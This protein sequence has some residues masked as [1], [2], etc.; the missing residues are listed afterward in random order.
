MNGGSSS[1]RATICILVRKMWEIPHMAK[2][3]T[4]FPD[5]S[6]QLLDVS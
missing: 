2:V 1:L 5:V 6:A 4:L 3:A